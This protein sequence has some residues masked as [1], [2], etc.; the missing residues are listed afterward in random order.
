MIN[1][2]REQ[3]ETALFN[4]LSSDQIFQ[5]TSDGLV[6]I[7][8]IAP[9]QYQGLYFGETITGTGVPDGTV[10]ADLPSAGVITLSNP[11]PAGAVNLVGQIFKRKERRLV[12]PGNV[13][14]EQRPA[15]CVFPAISAEHYLTEG[16]GIPPTITLNMIAIVYIS[17][18]QATESSGPPPM[19]F[20]NPIVDALVSIKLAPDLMT[21][22]QTL[23]KDSTG[24]P[25]CHHAYIEGEII[26]NGGDLDGLGVAII[27]IKILVP[28]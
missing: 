15:L 8:G 7:S 27:P 3:I 24:K 19:S 20:L 4:V 10:I 22:Q 2:S 9:L 25:Y 1:H 23:G 11:V 13:P 16:P 14:P 6:T 5:G 21:L 28:W 17:S 18:K 26:K 12:E